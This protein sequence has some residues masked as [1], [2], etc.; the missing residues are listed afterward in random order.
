MALAIYK[1]MANAARKDVIARYI[2]EL[3]MTKAGA[4]TYYQNAKKA[5]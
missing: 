4:S 1:E 2:S 5:A 3:G